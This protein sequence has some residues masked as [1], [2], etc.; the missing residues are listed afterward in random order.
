MENKGLSEVLLT[1]VYSKQET[2]VM[3]INKNKLV[4]KQVK[5]DTWHETF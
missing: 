1:R 4:V 5:R 3:E 2:L